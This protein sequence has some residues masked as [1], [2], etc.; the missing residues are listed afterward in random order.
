MTEWMRGNE[1]EQ[2]KADGDLGGTM[3]LGAYECVLQARQR[4]RTSIYGTPQISERHRHRYEVNIN[5]KDRLEQRRLAFLRHVAR[6]AYC[7][8]SWRSPI[9]RGSLACSSIRS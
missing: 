1:L 4:G 7:R 3:R 6:T 9:I 2:R 5:Y 8:R